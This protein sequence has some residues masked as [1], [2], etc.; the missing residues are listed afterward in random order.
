MSLSDA[1]DITENVGACRQLDRNGKEGSTMESD[2]EIVD[3]RDLS[4]DQLAEITGG[5]YEVANNPSSPAPV[6]L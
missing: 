6:G 1:P 4:D 2:F 3:I 5:S